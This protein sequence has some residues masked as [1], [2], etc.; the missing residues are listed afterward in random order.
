MIVLHEAGIIVLKARKVAGTS[1]EIALSRYATDS[2]IITPIIAEDEALRTRLGFR[3]PQNFRHDLSHFPNLSPREMLRAVRHLKMPPKFYNHIPAS[4]ARDLLG[5]KI[6]D[7]YKKVSIIRNP[8]DY[9]I[10]AYYWSIGQKKTPA[11]TRF[12][13]WVLNNP[14]ALVQNEEI[15]KIDGQNVIDVML[16]F[17][18]LQDDLNTLEDLHPSLSGLAE[19]FATITTKAAYRPKKATTQEIFSAAPRARDDIA[20]RMR[21]YIDRYSFPI[22]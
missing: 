3:G 5:G 17:D 22:P 9:M 18:R 12:E 8:F 20:T 4:A 21:D 7:Q 16:R 1:L 14:E 6:W 11:D 15:Y 13:D 2:S 10:S 19:T